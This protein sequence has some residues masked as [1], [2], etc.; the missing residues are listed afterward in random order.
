M[1]V[2]KGF[3][4]VWVCGYV[5]GG[6]MWVWVWVWG[7]VGGNRGPDVRLAERWCVLGLVLVMYAHTLCVCLCMHA[8]RRVDGMVV[9]T[10]THTVFSVCVCRLDGLLM[11]SAISC[12]DM[13][14]PHTHTKQQT[15]GWPR[16]SR[17]GTGPS[18]TKAKAKKRRNRK[19]RETR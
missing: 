3:V 15:C 9:V 7:C 10:Y 17:R 1:C 8:C 6:C 16:G 18:S 13:P 11:S 12:Y 19:R 2:K 5:C 4:E 14:P